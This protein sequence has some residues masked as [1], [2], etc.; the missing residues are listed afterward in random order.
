VGANPRNVLKRIFPDPE[1][2]EQIVAR[3]MVRPLRG[4]VVFLDLPWVDTHSLVAGASGRMNIA[5]P[6]TPPAFVFSEEEFQWDFDLLCAVYFP[7][8]VLLDQSQC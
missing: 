8:T 4:R 1:G 2:V 3:G 7:H 5:L 6:H